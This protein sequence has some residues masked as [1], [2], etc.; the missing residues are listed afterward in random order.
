MSNYY[1]DILEAN[2]ADEPI[3]TTQSFADAMDKAETWCSQWDEQRFVGV[4]LDE[5]LMAIFDSN[6]WFTK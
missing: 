2:P 3:A 1:V 4:W 5:V 6:D